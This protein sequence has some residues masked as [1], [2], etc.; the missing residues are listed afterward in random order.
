MNNIGVTLVIAINYDL[1][2]TVFNIFGV[3]ARITNS[4]AELKRTP[5]DFLTRSVNANTLRELIIWRTLLNGSLL[6]VESQ[7]YNFHF[8]YLTYRERFSSG[9][10]RPVV[11]HLAK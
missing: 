3:R 8:V 9:K 4:R 1:S 11:F 6:P 7:S 10:S 5:K 2:P